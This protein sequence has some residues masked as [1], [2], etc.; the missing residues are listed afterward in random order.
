[1][2]KIH[3]LHRGACYIPSQ[4]MAHS[5]YC[6]QFHRSPRSIWCAQPA[7]RSMADGEQQSDL[8]EI[9]ERLFELK[10]RFGHTF[11]AAAFQQ[12]GLQAF[13]R[14]PSGLPPWVSCPFSA[15]EQPEK[16]GPSISRHKGIP[17]HAVTIKHGLYFTKGPEFFF[18]PESA[19]SVIFRNL[20]RP[21]ALHLLL[22]ALYCG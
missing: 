9:R 4:R 18:L 19:S 15:L 11:V 6:L 8:S 14:R 17:K 13:R 16:G 5:L 20:N 21:D 1:M 10:H 2:E 12:L 22:I 3:K 7:T